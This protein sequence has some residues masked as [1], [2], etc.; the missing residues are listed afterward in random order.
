M[1]THRVI[2]EVTFKVVLDIDKDAIGE[3]FPGEDYNNRLDELV[4]KWSEE[5]DYRFTGENDVE[6]VDKYTELQEIKII[7]KEY[8]QHRINRISRSS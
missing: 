7:S 8:E 1:S 4:E 3:E 2:T 5:T 6:V